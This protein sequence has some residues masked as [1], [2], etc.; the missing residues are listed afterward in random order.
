MIQETTNTVVNNGSETPRGPD[1]AGSSDVVRELALAPLV[2]KLAYGLAR[3]FAVAMKDLED[4][5]AGENRKLGDTVGRRLDTLQS[6]VQDLTTALSE[7][8]AVGRA[9]Q[10]KCEQL[11]AATA[12]LR[13]TDVRHDAELSALR[14]ETRDSSTSLT[15]RIDGLSRELGVQQEDLA[16]TK[17]TACD[18]SAR[19][20]ALVERLERQS[21]AL[22]SLHTANVQR[23]TELDQLMEG[24]TK[25]RSSR[26]PLAASRL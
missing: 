8:Q 7:Q 13:E 21:E 11:T 26:A 1:G 5:I 3:I 20:D 24:L 25:L 14:N 17:S 2:E 22:R 23:D 16:A 12:S 9:V 6:S 18:I 19:V 4:H 15:E 10:A